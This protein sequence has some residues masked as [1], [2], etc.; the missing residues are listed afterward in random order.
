MP[1]P[2]PVDR[3]L[4]RLGEAVAEGAFVRIRLTSPTPA[5]APLRAVTG[6][7]VTLRGAPA[8]SLTLHEA[9]R[10]TTRNLMPDELAAWLA[11]RVPARFRGA[12][13]ETTARDWQLSVRADGRLQLVAH[14][15]RVTTA[16]A[17]AHDHRPA[18]PLGEDARDWLHAL[19]LVDANGGVPPRAA[20]KHRQVRRFA[21]LLGQLADDAGWAAG[22]RLELADA[23]CGKGHLTFAAWH[24]LRRRRGCDVRMT[25]L[26]R[27]P[28]L[29][30]RAGELAARLGLEG[31]SFRAGDIE[32]APVAALD[33]LIALHACN[34]ATDAALRHGVAA[35][36]RLL[37]A[38]PCCHQELRPQLA[39]PAALAPVARH[40]LFAERLAEWV[41]DGLRTLFLEWAGYRVK[42]VEFVAPEHTAK[43]LLLAAVRERQPFRDAAAKERLDAF[44]GAFGIARCALL[45]AI[46][47]AL[48]HGER[49]HADRAP[50]RGDVEEARASAEPLPLP[51]GEGRGE[52]PGEA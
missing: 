11:E 36:A 21:E 40:G 3:L 37:L 2:A 43:N 29:A 48:S 16:P 20:G 4:A 50:V 44:R 19:G 13:L 27:R 33:G 30:A 5:A 47:P 45:E 41:T 14:P 10:V 18:D 46:T 24:L 1:S 7:P 35:G 9:R 17:A 52:G 42:A 23:G 39:P 22:Q 38:A 31:L 26:E 32:S 15:P 8:V 12:L 51:A 49:G 25:G 28:E 34:T 6:R